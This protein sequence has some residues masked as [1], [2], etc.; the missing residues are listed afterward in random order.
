MIIAQP[1]KAF[2]DFLESERKAHISTFP[3]S[4]E[5]TSHSIS[6]K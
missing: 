4:L 1:V 5:S 6:L 3:K 2:P